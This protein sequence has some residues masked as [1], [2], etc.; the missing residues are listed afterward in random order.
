MIYPRSRSESGLEGLW[1]CTFALK[2]SKS[3]GSEWYLIYSESVVEEL[4]DLIG[5]SSLLDMAMSRNGM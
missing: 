5:K 4:C 1:K 3:V 2:Y